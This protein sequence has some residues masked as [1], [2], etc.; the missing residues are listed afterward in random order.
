MPIR[1]PVT[2]APLIWIHFIVIEKKV[3]LKP[4]LVYP[5]H[6][7]CE[8][9]QKNKSIKQPE[10]HCASRIKTIRLSKVRSADLSSPRKDIGNLF[11]GD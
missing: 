6:P 9:T 3:K 2:S 10:L 8:F 5:L 11:D 4:D 7:F 1:L